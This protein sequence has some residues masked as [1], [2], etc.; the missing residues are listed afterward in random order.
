MQT[1]TMYLRAD[2]VNAKF[3]DSFNQPISSLP[4]ITRGMRVNLVLKLLDGDGNPMTVSGYASWDFVLAHDFLSATPPQLRVTERINAVGNAIYIPLTET[5]T[6]ELIAILGNQA[7]MTIGAELAG[8][9]AGETTPGFLLQF[10][11]SVRNR[12]GDAGTG[13]PVPVA[14][15]NYSAPQINALFAAK[16]EVEF[17]LD[18][19]NWVREQSQD[20]R[21][22]RFRNAMVGLDWSDPLPLIIGPVGEQGIQGIQGI[23][24]DRATMQIGSVTTTAP[25][26]QSTIENVGDE[27]DAVFNFSLPQGVKGDKGVESYLYT[28]YAENPQMVGFSL[29]P[30]NH[31]KY[32]AEIVS[33][34]PLNP[35]TFADFA[36]AIWVKYLGDDGAV[37]GD[38]LVADQTTS[39]AK[40]SR[41]IFEN[42]SIREG[43]AGEV[44]VNFHNPG[45]S[46][47]AMR[48]FSLLNGKTRLSSWINGGGSPGG[49]SGVETTG[50]DLPDIKPI[51]NF[52]TFT[53]S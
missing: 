29:T 48:N 9:E 18:G 38:V 52:S 10:D 5:N 45:V 36:V 50:G 13:T 21:F 7:A 1:I 24:G 12:R 27:Y 49:D 32:R 30:A 4:A 20:S 46:D 41:I 47:E 3:V 35:P 11:I 39:V 33:R 17:S 51:D 28:A 34:V 8:F 31:L 37:F 6:E 26:S 23:K 16:L 22:Y 19:E 44:I 40:V 53:S 2:S 25:G 43:D 15:G 14:D 42:A